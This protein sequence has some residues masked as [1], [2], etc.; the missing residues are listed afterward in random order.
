MQSTHTPRNFTLS[1]SSHLNIQQGQA[2]KNQ[3]KKN[4]KAENMH[5]VPSGKLLS[6][7]QAGVFPQRQ[8]RAGGEQSQRHRAGRTKGTNPGFL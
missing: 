1:G 7:I 2:A 3:I 5:N 6:S 4:R 8:P